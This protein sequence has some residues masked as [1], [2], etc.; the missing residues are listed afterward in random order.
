[1]AILKKTVLFLLAGVFCLGCVGQVSA[2]S[3]LILPDLI[4][5][6]MLI[7]QAKPVRL[8][9]SGGGTTGETVTAEIKDGNTVINSGSGKIDANGKWQIEMP[10]MFVGG[11]YTVTFSANGKNKTV[12]NV[13]VGELWVQG[14][15]SN[16]ERTV[17]GISNSEYKNE[18]LPKETKNEIRLFYNNANIT[19]TT[20]ADD[21]DGKWV[22][23]GPSTVG[24]YSAVG[25]SALEELHNQLGVPV[26]GICNAIGG[27]GMDSFY[28]PSTPGGTGAG[29]YNAKTAPLT[30]FNIRGVMWYQGEA[31]RNESADGFATKLEKIITT[32]R[33][34]WND[35]DM[36]FIYV[37]L[38]A[39]PMRYW[40]SWLNAY[41]VEDF[42]TARLGQTKIYQSMD[43]VGMAVSIDCA[44][45][46]SEKDGEDALHP[47]NKKPIGQRLAYSALALAY[48]QD[49]VY[50]G[51]M[52]LSKSVDG[53]AMTLTFSNV[54]DGLK[55]TDGKAPRCFYIAGSDKKYYEAAA[56]IVGKN[57]LKLTS[58][59][60]ASPVHVAYSMEK[61]M[62]P[63]KD[64]NDQGA[65]IHTYPDVNLINSVGLP[66]SPFMTDVSYTPKE[67]KP[68]YLA[69]FYNRTVGLNS[70]YQLPETVEL[71]KPDGT[72]E[73]KKV[74]WSI[75]DFNT[76]T[77]K[78]Y[79][80][81]GF[82][83]GTD[84]IVPAA[85]KVKKLEESPVS[86]DI[87]ITNADGSAV[88][89]LTANAKIKMNVPIQNQA[90]AKTARLTLA[91]YSADNRLTGVKT[92]M[93]PIPANSTQS[94][95]VELTLPAGTDNTC[96]V[97]A[98]ITDPNLAPYAPARELT[99][100]DRVVLIGI[101]EEDFDGNKVP[102]SIYE[103]YDFNT[104]EE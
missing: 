27:V 49:V 31:N 22:I 23:A 85:V 37:Q 21:L 47:W 99:V 101:T 84:C 68:S 81:Y 97:K 6:N 5:D 20:A 88:N 19:Q 90:T 69:G 32:W 4:S 13:L 64:Y 43:K 26:G 75:D 59:Q 18:I 98:F 83:E 89:N 91:V 93:A 36:P 70:S 58:S 8:W 2:A 15:Q 17:N 71:T 67:V 48:G 55:T 56:E 50:S 79:I 9:G 66:V 86:G 14:G 46:H 72:I 82:P 62:Y 39:S 96:R 28:G 53:N 45:V 61:I 52:Y 74:T 92:L 100:K 34:G 76:K 3:D 95:S 77:E 78:S 94:L 11:P 29:S 12:S 104:E 30:N 10:A 25:Y 35:P 1:M 7:Q 103:I 51:P 33:N 80:F 102:V 87:T 63:Y 40:A 16:M 24:G 44:P 60:V 38:P 54:E 42:S 41:I 65:V 57:Q 73:V